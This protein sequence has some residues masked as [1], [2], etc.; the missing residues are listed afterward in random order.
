LGAL[1]LAF[2]CAA[3]GSSRVMNTPGRSR[4]RQ[5]VTERRPPLTK[6]EASEKRAAASTGG[7]LLKKPHPKTHGRRPWLYKTIDAPGGAPGERLRL[8][9]GL[10]A[11]TGALACTHGPHITKGPAFLSFAIGRPLALRVSRTSWLPLF[12]HL[13]P[14]PPHLNKNRN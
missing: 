4:R 3:K 8:A 7:S 11:P 14:V 12:L 2:Y 10:V 6:S 13:P 9:C 5:L 1:R